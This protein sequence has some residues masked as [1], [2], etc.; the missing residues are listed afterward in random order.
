MRKCG[1][2]LHDGVTFCA[3]CGTSTGVSGPTAAAGVAPA[4]SHPIGG[5][6]Q[7][8]GFFGS[9]FDLSFTSF[10]TTKLIKLLFVLAIIA[11]ALGAI[12]LIVYTNTRL[13]PIPSWLGIVL[14]PIAFFL[15]VLIAR[16]YMEII[17]VTF[18]MVEYLREIAEQGRGR[19]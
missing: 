10:V 14:A 12:G 9:L 8:R 15:Y 4:V 13:T 3:N 7:Q 18:R 1:A 19:G 5:V 11:S 2:Q 16:V 17:M 6:P